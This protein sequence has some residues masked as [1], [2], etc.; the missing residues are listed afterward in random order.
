MDVYNDVLV[1]AED[2]RTVERRPVPPRE[3]NAVVGI[4]LGSERSWSGAWCLWP[5]GRSECYAVCPG[6]PDLAERERQDAMPGGLY[7]RLCDD[8]VLLVDEGLRVSRPST[9]IDFLVDEKDITIE[10]MLSDRFHL[11]SMQ[12]AVAG[13]WPVVPR[14]VRWSEATEDISAFWRLVVD[15][16][17]SIVPECRAL[18]RVALS[19]ASVASDDHGSVR[20]TK[21]RHGRSRDDVAVAGTLAAGL[22]V[23]SMSRKSP[24]RWTYRGMAA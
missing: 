3:G 12:D 11:A 19:Q 8:G 10:T 20:L 21:K 24:R 2:W 22:L 14:V 16:P 6:I 4:D 1:K 13:P 23:R 15:G 17:L 9:L 5:N 7:K 18:A